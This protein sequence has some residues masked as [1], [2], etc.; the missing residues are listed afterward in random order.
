MWGRGDG[1]E[2][3]LK[4]KGKVRQFEDITVCFMLTVR[5]FTFLCLHFHC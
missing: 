2:Q 5:L 4:G 3:T 1:D